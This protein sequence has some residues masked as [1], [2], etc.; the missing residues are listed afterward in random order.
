MRFVSYSEVA[1][2]VRLLVGAILLR[3]SLLAPLIFAHFL[4]L[5]FYMSS[6]TRAS[7]QAVGGQLDAWTQRSECPPVVRRA[8]LTLMDLLSRYASSVMS[9]P[10]GPAPG[11]GASG[12]SASGSGAQAA[13]AAGASGSGSGSTARQ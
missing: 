5:R 12:R 3:N 4:R 10:Q 2:F 7:W 13:T 8:Y 6:F 1:I 11:N 9:V